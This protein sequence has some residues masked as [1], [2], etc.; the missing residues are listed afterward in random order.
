MKGFIP[1]HFFPTVNNC[2]PKF[3]KNGAGFALIELLIVLGIIVILSSLIA[4]AIRNY[5]SGFQLL[6]SAREIVTDLRYIQQ[7]AIT[8]QVEYCFK[9]FSAGKKY[10][11]KQ[12]DSQEIIK[13]EA[14]PQEIKTLSSSGFTDE[15]IR[16]NPYG[17]V[18]E[19]GIIILED[20]KDETK[21]I[22]VKP[23]GFVEI[24]N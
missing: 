3:I 7:L 11:I 16:Y 22:Q 9:V 4:P 6:G 21:T 10:Q 14:M 18:S 15:E 19:A 24:N 8:E 13:E 5:Q 20:I 12:C 17:A 1:H 2:Y 23:S